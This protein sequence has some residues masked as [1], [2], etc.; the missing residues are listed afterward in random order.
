MKSYEGNTLGN[1]GYSS[2]QCQGIPLVVGKLS[3]SCP[4]GV[5]GEFYDYGVNSE[6]DGGEPGSCMTTDFNEAC[7]PTSQG[8]KDVLASAVG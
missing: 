5:V 7:K 1:L 2:V 3:I 8:F 4:F 6:D